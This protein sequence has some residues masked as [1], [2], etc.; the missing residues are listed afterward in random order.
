MV[1]YVLTLFQFTYFLYTIFMQF[2][3]TAEIQTILSM[4]QTTGII[5]SVMY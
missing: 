3:E 5:L 2:P 4:C 1:L